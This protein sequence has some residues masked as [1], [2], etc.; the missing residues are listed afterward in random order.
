MKI[1]IAAVGK[2]KR[3][4][5]RDLCDTYAK[6][7]RWDLGLRE[8]ADR[9]DGSAKLRKSK[10]AEGLLSGLPA[11]GKIIAL[12][13]TG[14]NPSSTDFSSLLNRWRE[15][16]V[17]ALTFIIGG[18]DGLDQTVRARADRVLAFGQA[19]WPHMMV[20]V[21]LYEQLYRAWTITSGHPYHR[22]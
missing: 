11:Q 14:D 13:E 7:I 18:A 1:A 3:G 21:M 10:E 9:N 15:D 8:I 16:G 20:R 12:D 2:M 19:T 5:M 4:P 22:E 6:R 17:P